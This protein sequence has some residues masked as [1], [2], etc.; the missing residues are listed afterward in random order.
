MQEVAA[1]QFRFNGEEDERRRQAEVR[2]AEISDRE[3]RARQQVSTTHAFLGAS[4][5]MISSM[6]DAWVASTA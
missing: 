6:R 5:N 1:W 4:R 2:E 3:R